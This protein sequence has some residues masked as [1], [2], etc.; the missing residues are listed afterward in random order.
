MP[1]LLIRTAD[2]K[3]RLTELDGSTYSINSVVQPKVPEWDDA[4]VGDTVTNPEPSFVDRT[5]NKLLFFRNRFCILADEYIVMSRPGDFTNFFA[6][7]AIQ[8]VASDPID[9][10]ASST[11]PADIFDGI[12]TNTGLVY[13]L[14]INSSWSLQIVMCSVL[15]QLR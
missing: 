1:V 10:A 15:K 11:Y 4:L 12:Q 7:S 13:F 14:K 9:I 5:I 2:A 6:K 8:F 3:F